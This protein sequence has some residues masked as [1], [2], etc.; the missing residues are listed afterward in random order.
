VALK[1]N[2]TLSPSTKVLLLGRLVSALNVGAGPKDALRDAAPVTPFSVV[3][4]GTDAAGALGVTVELV[5]VTVPGL[6]RATGLVALEAP[7]VLPVE[8]ADAGAAAC[9]EPLDEL[10]SLQAASVVAHIP[11]MRCIE[12]FLSAGRIGKPVHVP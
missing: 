3:F 5:P 8:L 11:I 4:T 1:F 7:A 10:W 2:P 6:F 12:Y 9:E